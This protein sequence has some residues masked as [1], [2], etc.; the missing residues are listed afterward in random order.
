MFYWT[1]AFLHQDF[2]IMA[3]RLIFA[4]ILCG[5]I[6]MERELKSHP[7]GFRT[8]ML[9]GIGSCLMMLLSLYGFDSFIK[10]YS[11]IVNIDP[12]RI[13][14]YVISGIGFLGAGT[15]IFHGNTVK[16]LTTAASIWVV[17]GIG[18]ISGIGMYGLAVLATVLVTVSLNLSQLENFIQKKNTT[19]QI[20]V[21]SSKFR[22]LPSII[23]TLQSC[24]VNIHGCSISK[25]KNHEEYNEKIMFIFKCKKLETS[26]LLNLY[27][28]L[29]EVSGVIKVDDH[30]LNNHINYSQKDKTFDL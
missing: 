8:H 10:T 25:M 9:V 19:K 26:T 1:T 11:D 20:V 28:N 6:G 30:L 13:P 23:K 21:I 12:A 18:L 7:A 29:Y 3:F 17:A 14:S 22:D 2:I 5:V 24:D 27:E 15:I 4:S 16:G